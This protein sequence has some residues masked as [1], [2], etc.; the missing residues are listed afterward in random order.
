M[1]KKVLLF[2]GISL[3]L[4][5]SPVFAFDHESIEHGSSLGSTADQNA[6]GK[7]SAKE[8]DA[9]LNSC[10]QQMN[11]IHRNIARLQGEMVE[12]HAV[13]NSIIEELK[14]LEEKLK[15][16]NQIVRPLHLF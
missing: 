9:I 3:I 14:K 1:K 7:E 4:A 8:V 15:E 5:A 10:S 6:Q 11:S 12:N 16:G 13:A 2:A